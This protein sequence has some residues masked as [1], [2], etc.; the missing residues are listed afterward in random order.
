MINEI[1]SRLSQEHGFSKV[2]GSNEK[3]GEPRLHFFRYSGH[4]KL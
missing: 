1:H 4:E 3:A 2:F